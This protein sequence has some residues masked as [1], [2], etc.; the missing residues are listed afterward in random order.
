MRNVGG[1]KAKK[2]GEGSEAKKDEKLAPAA[3]PDSVFTKIH[4]KFT[5]AAGA[6]SEH[7]GSSGSAGSAPVGQ[8]KYPAMPD[9]ME[10]EEEEE[11][12]APAAEEKEEKKPKKK[13][14]AAKVEEEEEEEEGGG[15]RGGAPFPSHPPPP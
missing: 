1:G 7:K 6:A 5:Y 8:D 15:G 2:E 11:E 12:E 14:K 10:V 13:A 3:M 4:K 9:A